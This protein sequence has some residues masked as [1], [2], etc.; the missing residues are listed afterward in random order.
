M[1]IKLDLS[2]FLE[3]ERKFSV[4]KVK[5]K[6]TKTVRDVISKIS[7]L[8]SVY[9]EECGEDDDQTRARLGLFDEEF[10]IHPDETAAVLEDS[11]VLKLK[12]LPRPGTKGKK[13]KKSK[14][15]PIPVVIAEDDERKKL[16]RD[17]EEEKKA[18]GV[19]E[20]KNDL[21]SSQ[22]TSKEA[23][24]AEWLEGEEDRKT[25]KK[26]K[27]CQFAEEV[28]ELQ[29]KK[30]SKIED[31]EPGLDES[32]GEQHLK[33]WK[34]VESEEKKKRKKERASR[35]LSISDTS[36]EERRGK[37]KKEQLQQPSKDAHD[38][39]SSH[40]KIE[41]HASI[42]EQPH[43]KEWKK[44]RLKDDK[45]GGS[46]SS[47]S[48]DK[49]VST[50]SFLTSLEGISQHHCR[51]SSNA[52][53][54]LDLDAE[55]RKPCV[56]DSVTDPFS[57]KGEGEEWLLKRK[58]KRKHKARERSWKS[59]AGTSQ[60]RNGR[61][62]Q[63]VWDSEAKHPV[64]PGK[65]MPMTIPNTHIIFN[66]DDDDEGSTIQIRSDQPSHQNKIINPTLT[67]SSGQHNQ[68]DAVL[69]PAITGKVRDISRE[70]RPPVAAASP[71][72]H[73]NRR[74][75]GSLLQ[76]TEVEQCS[77]LYSGEHSSQYTEKGRALVHRRPAHN[78]VEELATLRKICENNTI[79]I[80]K[81]DSWRKQPT[82][83]IEE[84]RPALS[85]PL[86]RAPPSPPHSP[87]QIV[88]DSKHS[89]SLQALTAMKNR[90]VPV[91]FS[92]VRA[93]G[94][95]PIQRRSGTSAPVRP[96]MANGS[97]GLASQNTTILPADDPLQ[98]LS[99]NLS[100]IQQQYNQGYEQTR[101]ERR[102][103]ALN[104]LGA[105]LSAMKTK[106]QSS[107]TDS[108]LMNHDK[109]KPKSSL[110]SGNKGDAGGLGTSDLIILGCIEGTDSKL[111]AS[112]SKKE[113]LP[114]VY[115]VSPSSPS[116]STHQASPSRPVFQA[117][118]S[119]PV[120][121]TS[122]SRPVLQTSHSRLVSQIS[123]TKPLSQTSPSRPVSHLSPP[124]SVPQTSISKP[125]PQTI[126][127]RLMPQASP[128]KSMTET[129]LSR[130]IPHTNPCRPVLQTSPS[131]PLLQENLSRPL[132]QSML[133][134]TL[135]Q[136]C[137]S[138]PLEQARPPHVATVPSAPK[139]PVDEVVDLESDDQSEEVTCDK[140]DGKADSVT[141]VA[142]PAV[143]AAESGK[144]ADTVESSNRKDIE[145]TT[146][147]SRNRIDKNTDARD[148][149]AP[150]KPTS[151]SGRLVE[152]GMSTG[153]YIAEILE[154]C[155][156]V[157]LSGNGT[158]K[159]SAADARKEVAALVHHAEVVEEEVVSDED[160]V[161]LED[162]GDC[163]EDVEGE[164]EE[165][166]EDEEEE[167][168]EEE[169]EGEEDEVEEE[170]IEEVQ[171]EEEE[172]DIY[173]NIDDE[174]EEMEEEEEEED[175]FDY[176]II[177]ESGPSVLMTAKR[178][179][180]QSLASDGARGS[181]GAPNH[182]NTSF[183]IQD[184]TSCPSDSPPKESM[185]SSHIPFKT[186][187]NEDQGQ[188]AS[189]VAEPEITSILTK[190]SE[191]TPFVTKSLEVI[192][193]M[194]KSAEPTDV[195]M[196]SPETSPVITK[197]SE[198]APVV[199]LSPEL[200]P[201]MTKPQEVSVVTEPEVVTSL[202]SE[203]QVTSDL[204][205]T[206][207]DTAILIE[208]Q[209]NTSLAEPQEVKPVST[210]PIMTKPQTAM[211]FVMEPSEVTPTM[212]EPVEV[213]PV[214]KEPKEV[215]TVSMESE[216]T[217]V[218]TKSEEIAPV[219]IEPEEISPVMTES[220]EAVLRKCEE[221]KPV[222]KSHETIRRNRPGNSPEDNG[223]A[224]NQEVSKDSQSATIAAVTATS[225]TSVAN[226]GEQ[227]TEELSRDAEP[228]KDNS[229]Q[230]SNFSY[231]EFP[232][233]T[234]PPK[235]GDFI[236][237][238]TVVMEECY[239]LTLTDYQVAKVLAVDGVCVKLRFVD[240][241]NLQIAKGEELSRDDPEVD[242]QIKEMDWRDIV[243]PR[244]LFSSG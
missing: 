185:G 244:V 161:M 3:D 72:S 54:D 200:I 98:I 114:D 209:E 17:V 240:A 107:T 155:E 183:K 28:E 116:I 22:A 228:A 78:N 49:V 7:Q 178:Q 118:S 131:T 142:P 106:P 230:S 229:I 184:S 139:W 199:S 187:E 115:C 210:E 130:P 112:P 236:A 226:S 140:S 173:A 70:R 145:D 45:G 48:Q 39:A 113:G 158:K 222:S 135:Q 77:T 177:K 133:S 213:M 169:E 223:E 147:L 82:K 67:V 79:T 109:E 8:F 156:M 215:M 69:T 143:T 43:L 89:A 92:G 57:S 218:T 180:A 65:V 198:S 71:S 56:A 231:H 157:G 75:Q 182:S 34:E 108:S 51:R 124:K 29:R 241:T 59:D 174:D 91:V 87:L 132:S 53:S 148:L 99:S 58:R 1:R 90:N 136:T 26:R 239:S 104:S 208:P 206:E 207:D 21:K 227:K 217:P 31:W 234:A 214:I 81:V 127:S 52:S 141:V 152:G 165:E 144:L 119:R 164:V 24:R 189:L 125:I 35:E 62:V 25:N 27:R 219:I 100:E 129:S 55:G 203:P 128:S 10:Y 42:M 103:A 68:P 15:E 38:M 195:L 205:E 232:A 12:S 179:E 166:E 85:P 221:A 14:K 66:D 188:I 238:K 5:P 102:P 225:S 33:G 93:M 46:S 194:T 50:S 220:S 163:V 13:K 224:Q 190:P 149:H 18:Q 170:V 37:K 105:I 191:A 175:D 197:T 94:V 74:V 233:L 61:E 235:A 64:L 171:D 88:H 176:E 30:R 6:E 83:P 41:Q 76:N 123:T 110:V 44:Q 63:N 186:L 73:G 11:G 96:P 126:P 243:E 159:A 212:M 172:T 32:R 101:T 204:A 242:T 168:E 181:A 36:Q 40:K 19:Q 9:G 154:D 137:P 84:P 211:P 134:R 121:Q 138:K 80:C 97:P 2:D 153:Q 20:M 160:E 95:R 60:P 4:L 146:E 23:T 86:R 196:L 237:L 120:P 216:V 117:T 47:S 201:A 193:V 202:A 167:E 122:Q 162:D 150:N 16:Q 111:A 192:P 151:I